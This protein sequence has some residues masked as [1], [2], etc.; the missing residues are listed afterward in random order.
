MAGTRA[1]LAPEPGPG[2]VATRLMARGAARHTGASGLWRESV[3]GKRARP[4]RSGA[5]KA[6]RCD[7][8]F[9]ARNMETAGG[10]WCEVGRGLTAGAG[11]E[12]ERRACS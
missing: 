8:M 6:Q 1:G 5:A 2:A 10:C 9:K 7:V 11:E 4:G 3:E 12:G